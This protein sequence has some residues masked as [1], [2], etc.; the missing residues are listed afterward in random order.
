MSCTKKINFIQLYYKYHNLRIADY[1]GKYGNTT[2]EV[3]G[4]LGNNTWVKG[5]R[6]PVFKG[7]ISK[8]E[9]LSS[10]LIEGRV[11]GLKFEFN[12]EIECKIDNYGW[13]IL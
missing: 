4:D 8:P 7:K 1:C 2:L 12:L 11:D 10:T 9:G 5:H 3:V 6:G 13:V